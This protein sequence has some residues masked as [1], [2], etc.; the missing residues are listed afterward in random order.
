MPELSIS[1]DEILCFYILTISAYISVSK[2]ARNAVIGAFFTSVAM[3]LMLYNTCSIVAIII[4]IAYVSILSLLLLITKNVEKQR[5]TIC[6]KYDAYFSLVIIALCE[7]SSHSPNMTKL[8]ISSF[9]QI[10]EL[11]VL[12]VTLC[13]FVMSLIISMIRNVR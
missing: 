2:N 4:G 10:S 7:I 8:A 12:I 5:E 13:M 11:T 6:I 9:T 3:S 1:S